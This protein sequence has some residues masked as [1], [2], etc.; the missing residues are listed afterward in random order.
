MPWK[1]VK[2][3]S[4]CPKS[5][6]WA[7]VGGASGSRV[8]G[9]HPSRAHAI[10][11]QRALYASEASAQDGTLSGDLLTEEAGMTEILEDTVASE[12]NEAVEESEEAIEGLASDDDEL[13]IPDVAD[14]IA[15][16]G[17]IAFEGVPTGDSGMKR[18]LMPGSIGWRDL[19][20][21]L[22]AQFANEEG[23]GGAQV[24][25]RIDSL[26][27]D[28]SPEAQAQYGEGVTVIYGEGVFDSGDAGQQAAR[29]VG[30]N[31]MNGISIDLTDSVWKIRDP[32]TND[33][34]AMNELPEELADKFFAN[35]LQIALESGKIGAATIVPIPALEDAEVA[36]AANAIVFSPVLEST[37]T[38]VD[39]QINEALEILR[40]VTMRDRYE[41]YK[42]GLELGLLTRE[43]IFRAEGLE[44]VQAAKV[45]EEAET[46]QDKKAIV[47]EALKTITEQLDQD[48]K[49]DATI[50]GTLEA[51]RAESD[52]D[53][54]EGDGDE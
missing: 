13:N 51:I 43:D 16:S 4:S 9:C 25:G 46:E 14:P 38:D 47:L 3:H 23:H 35:E 48:D 36:I 45:V 28:N 19:P 18:Y 53:E 22:M 10:K 41:G 12:D 31:V 32:E 5:K 21:T 29:M 7:V 52:D 54:E 30:D 37:D 44:L 17:P 2:G 49:F 27:R 26:R 50:L 6:P 20:M 42:L 24:A 39:D 8:A 1:L 34:Y 15:W 33:L 11:Q 40:S